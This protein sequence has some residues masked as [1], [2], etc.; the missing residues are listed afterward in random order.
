MFPVLARRPLSHAAALLLITLATVTL[1]VFFL[2]TGDPVDMME[3]FNLVPVREAF[4]DGHW[5]MPTLNGVPRLEK[6]PLPVWI[7][8]AFVDFFHHDS[9]WILRLPSLLMGL[10]TGIAT[11]GLGCVLFENPADAPKANR[12]Y[13]LLAAVLLPAMIIFNR[14]ARLASY[15]IFATAFLTCGAAFLVALAETPRP[16]PGRWWLLVAGAGVT[17]GL[18]V[19]SKGPVPVATVMLPLGL[20]L[21]LFHRRLPVFAGVALA[22]LFSVATFFPWLYVIGH[23]YPDAWSRWKSEFIQFGTGHAVNPAAAG[24]KAQLQKSPFYYLAF[25]AWVAPLTPLVIAGLCLPFLKSHADPLPADRERRGRWLLWLLLVG[26]LLLLTLP[27]EK[28]P[29]YALQLFPYA[30][31]LCAAV[32]QEFV[33][34]RTDRK[35]EPAAILLLAG[36]AI[37]FIGPG[38]AGLL[39]VVWIKCGFTPPAFLGSARGALAA[40]ATPL[41]ALLFALVAAAGIYLWH[42]QFRRRF[43]EALLWLALCAW[44]VGIVGQAA[45]RMDPGTHTNAVHAPLEQALRAAAGHPLYTFPGGDVRPWLSSLY[46]AD[47]ALPERTLD[48]LIAEARAHPT[49]PLFLMFIDDHGGSPL[50]AAF[51]AATGR[52]RTLLGAWEDEGRPTLLLRFDPPSPAR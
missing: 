37:C 28:K 7:P 16:T 21:L 46:F 14:Q 51:Q 23:Q 43:A 52:T 30:A 47:Q 11:Y 40:M 5:L 17:T 12:R 49:D 4:R 42:L 27:S 33:R 6:P 31:L 18:S 36:Q 2:G 41:F 39:A 32:W 3:L 44:G 15:D 26:G 22:A 35:L 8:A 50:A 13:A 10:L 45:Y 9:L 1:L 24:T 38:V 34:L 19:M 20:W 48:Q 29:R 25:L